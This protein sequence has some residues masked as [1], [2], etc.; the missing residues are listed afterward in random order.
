MKSSGNENVPCFTSFVKWLLNMYG[1]FHFF[2]CTL[3]IDDNFSNWGLDF[4]FKEADKIWTLSDKCFKGADKEQTLQI[5]FF[6][7]VQNKI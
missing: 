1:T 3:I 5:S 6:K 2:L 7:R 4:S